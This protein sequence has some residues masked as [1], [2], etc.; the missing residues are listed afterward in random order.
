M[1]VRVLLIDDHTLFRKG[2][3]ELLER[4]EQISVAGVAGSAVEAR[5]LLAELKPDVMVTDLHMQPEDGLSLLLQLQQEGNTIPTLVLT[6]SNAEEDLANVLRAGARGYLLKDMEPDDVAD[7]IV[8]AARGETV[9]APSMT[10]KLVGLLQNNHPAT[11]PSSL[12]DL[13]TQRE[14]EILS[15]LALGESNKVI[16]RQLDISHDTVKLHVR[17]ILSK[18]NLTSRVEAAIFAVEYKLS[19]APLNSPT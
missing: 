10:M 13:L 19:N 15:H 6:V 8:R 17:H 11:Q 4:N 12:L 9:V 14:R 2:L 3:A 7:A 5:K 16:A 18:L 1:T